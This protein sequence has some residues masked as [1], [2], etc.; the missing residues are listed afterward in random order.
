MCT[1]YLDIWAV[2]GPGLGLMALSI[3]LRFS[4]GSAFPY[5]LFLAWDRKEPR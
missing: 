4:V 3:I 2:A 5:D 1:Y